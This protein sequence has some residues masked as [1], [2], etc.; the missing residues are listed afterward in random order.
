MNKMFS[1]T[2]QLMGQIDLLLLFSDLLDGIFVFIKLAIGD[3][4]IFHLS[5]KT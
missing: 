2:D 3:A 4:N 1:I 5:L